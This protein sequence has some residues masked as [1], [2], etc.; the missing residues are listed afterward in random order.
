[1]ETRKRVPVALELYTVRDR[2][3]R[4]YAGTLRDV[5]ALGYRAVEFAGYGGLSADELTALLHETGLTAAATHVSLDKLE[6][7][8]RREIEFC[9]AIACSYLVLPG[10]PT[11]FHNVAGL[12]RLAERLNAIGRQCVEQGVHFG[13]HNHD[14]E[15]ASYDEQFGLDIMLAETDST[16]V[17][18]EFDVYWAAH[19]GVDPDRFLRRNAGRIPLLHLKDRAPDGGFTE[20][21]DGDLKLDAL[22]ALASD[23]GVEWCIVENDAPTLD[24]LESAR[25]SLTNLQA[26]GSKA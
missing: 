6:S 7:D 26:M 20:V 11:E 13:Y 5:A 18:F 3:A 2:T 15:F 22:Y 21:G 9:Q 8:L 23:V 14:W 25:R 12:H 1:M 10:V 4:N 24:S 16:T 17:G 19:A